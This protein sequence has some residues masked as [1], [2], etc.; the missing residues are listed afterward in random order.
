[1]KK[2]KNRSVLILQ[3]NKV[4]IDRSTIG[5]TDLFIIRVTSN[6]A[7]TYVYPAVTVN[8]ACPAGTETPISNV[9]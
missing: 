4:V 9:V 5:T 6:N 8:I 3:N 1:M 7:Y 2:K